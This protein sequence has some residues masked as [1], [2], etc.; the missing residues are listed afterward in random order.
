VKRLYLFLTLSALAGLSLF[1]LAC[2]FPPSYPP[3]YGGPATSTPTPTATIPPVVISK[4]AAFL[5]S[6]GGSGGAAVSTPITISLG[7][8]VVWDPSNSGAL[9]ID[10]MASVCDLD[11]AS[12]Y[13][14][15]YAFTTAGNFLA[16]NGTYGNC[17]GG[18]ASCP[19]SGPTGMAVTI[20]V[21]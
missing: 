16:H 14:V 10:N 11:G 4:N 2:A 5:Y 3:N 18:S 15:T 20:N 1:P 17:S 13:P 19:C 7:Q 8:A 6:T 9:Y 12:A 21:P